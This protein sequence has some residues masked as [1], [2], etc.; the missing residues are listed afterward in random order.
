MSSVWQQEAIKAADVV[1]EG[2]VILYPT[3]TIWGLGCDAG[4]EEAVQ[5]IRQ[6]K[7][8]QE[9]KSFIILVRDEEQLK[10]QVQ[11]V[12]EQ[13]LALIRETSRPLTVIYEGVQKLADGV[14]AN[15]GTVAIRVVRDA[16]CQRLIEEM[17]RPLVSTSANLSGQ[18][19][20]GDFQSIPQAIKGAVDY[21][22]AYRQD[23]PISSPPSKIVKVTDGGI[24]VIRE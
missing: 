8:R 21:V 10:A 6:I 22:V 12:P 23:E 2:G 18:A 3:D 20:K 11:H 15:D 7:G 24:A 5:R 1:L 17:E 14:Y 4:N 19:T 9:D 16:F 13:A